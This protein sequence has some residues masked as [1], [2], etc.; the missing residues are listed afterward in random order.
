VLTGN[1]LVKRY[2]GALFAVAKDNDLV[3]DIFGSLQNLDRAFQEVPQLKGFILSPEVASARKLE[4]LLTSVGDGSQ[5]I[6]KRFFQLVIHKNR[7]DIL[8]DIFQAYNHL[9]EE[10]LGRVEVQVTTAVLASPKMK[11]EITQRLSHLTSKTPVVLWHEDPTLLGGYRIVIG[12]KSYDFSLSR[13]LA[14]IQ[15]QMIE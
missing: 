8:P 11:A 4:I 14:M 12:N 2:V 13:Q 3:D 1:I 5:E 7:A 6:L 15:E 9:R 10:A